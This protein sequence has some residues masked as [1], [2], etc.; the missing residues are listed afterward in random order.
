MPDHIHVCLDDARETVKVF[1][2]RWKSYVTNTSWKLGWSGKLWQPKSY[3]EHLNTEQAVEKAVSYIL[4]NPEEA[5]L[6]KMWK[7]YPYWAEP[8]FGKRGWK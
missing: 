2:E 8:P 7:E 1:I 3:P 5:G 6:V 4:S